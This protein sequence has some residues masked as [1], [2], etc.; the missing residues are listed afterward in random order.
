[1][2]THDLY[3]SVWLNTNLSDRLKDQGALTDESL[4]GVWE[5]TREQER[6]LTDAAQGERTEGGYFRLRNCHWHYGFGTGLM[7]SGHAWKRD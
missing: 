4:E 7:L 1:M 5:T 2:H 3:L 6:I